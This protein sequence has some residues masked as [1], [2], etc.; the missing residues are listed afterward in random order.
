MEIGR[1]YT[2]TRGNFSLLSPLPL[3]FYNERAVFLTQKRK[4][5]LYFV[6]EVNL[7]GLRLLSLE[8]FAYKV[9][10]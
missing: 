5:R 3:I 8:S 2:D 9:G 1:W 4:P 6:H 7:E 10:P